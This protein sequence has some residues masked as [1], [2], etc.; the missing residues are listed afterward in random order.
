MT[1]KLI[2]CLLAGVL[3][4]AM[5]AAVSQESD[6]GAETEGTNN[7]SEL[8]RCKASSENLYGNC[9]FSE[10]DNADDNCLQQRHD[11]LLACYRADYIRDCEASKLGQSCADL[12]GGT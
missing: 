12:F 9:K 8:L 4:A 6:R 3:G 1:K 2:A 10:G 11:L 5:A 7:I